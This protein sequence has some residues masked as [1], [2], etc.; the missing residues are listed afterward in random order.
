MNGSRLRLSAA[1]AQEVDLTRGS[2]LAVM[3]LCHDTDRAAALSPVRSTFVSFLRPSIPTL[4]GATDTQLP[5]HPMVAVCALSFPEAPLVQCVKH[6]SSPPQ[7]T[8]MVVTT[9]I[10]LRHWPAL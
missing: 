1:Q 4:P 9:I 6:I 10:N 2:R 8:W 7:F 5:I 3:P